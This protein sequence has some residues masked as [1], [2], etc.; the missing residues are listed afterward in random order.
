MLGRRERAQEVDLLRGGTLSFAT[1]N[2]LKPATRVL[3]EALPRNLSGRVLTALDSEAAVALAAH[4]LYAGAALVH[5][6]LDLHVAKQATGSV[7]ATRRSASPSRPGPICRASSGPRRTE[8]T[9]ASLAS[10]AM[11]C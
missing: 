9:R 2:G 1:A 5:C 7:R 6:E 4:A 10:R 3:I 11:R 8:R